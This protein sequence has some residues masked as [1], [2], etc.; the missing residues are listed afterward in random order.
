MA[1]FAGLRTCVT[2]PIK[3]TFG[4]YFEIIIKGEFFIGEYIMSNDD[5]VF[6]YTDKYYADIL[7]LDGSTFDENEYPELFKYLGT[8][9]LE[10][11]PQQDGSFYKVV[12]DYKTMSKWLRADTYITANTQMGEFV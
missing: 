11:Q 2:S 3:G 1:I 8:N 7:L 9:I 5:Y 10:P 12:A 4:A 6:D